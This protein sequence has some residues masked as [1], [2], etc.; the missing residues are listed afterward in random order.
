MFTRAAHDG[1]ERHH[2][3]RADDDRI[4]AAPGHGAVRLL[5]GD[6]NREPV[7]AR[8]QRPR[9]ILD[10]PGGHGKHVQSEDRVDLRVVE[11][12]F[13]DH[14]LGAALLAGGRPFLGGLKDQLDRARQL[15][16][17]AREDGGGAQQDRHVVVVATGVHHADF[18]PVP[19]RLRGGLER[20]VALLGH[21]QRI[22]VRSQR[23]DRPRLAALQH[24]DHAGV[25]HA[26]LSP[27]SPAAAVRRR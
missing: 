12:A 16:A 19:R 22:H 6:T 10:R 24:G 23:H 13:L 1:L 27:R 9:A 8:H 20:Q 25:R 3:L 26:G 17:H 21:R 18:L 11:H 7:A 14:Q 5:A 4:D 2:D 15:V